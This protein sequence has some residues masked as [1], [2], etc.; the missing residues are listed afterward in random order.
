MFFTYGADLTKKKLTLLPT[1]GEIRKMVEKGFEDFQIDVINE[2]RT[3]RIADTFWNR[4][5]LKKLKIDF[6]K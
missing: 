5:K 3:V 4:R 6:K 1:E 2:K